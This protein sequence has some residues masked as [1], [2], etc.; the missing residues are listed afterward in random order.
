LEC[1]NPKCHNS[2]LSPPNTAAPLQLGTAAFHP[3][4]TTPRYSF[5]LLF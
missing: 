3:G 2:Q 1:S 5:F 4:A